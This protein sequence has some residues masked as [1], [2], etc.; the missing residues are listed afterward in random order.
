MRRLNRFIQGL[1]TFLYYYFVC[2]FTNRPLRVEFTNAIAWFQRRQRESDVFPSL[3]LTEVL[4]EASGIDIHLNNFAY[5]GGN[6]SFGELCALAAMVRV[7]KPK[8]LFEFG[9]F[10][11]NTTLQLALN[12][13]RD[14]VV[15]TIDLP[16]GTQKTKLKISKGDE[17]IAGERS[18]HR[19]FNGTEFEHRIRPILEDSATYDYSILRTRV[20]LVFVDGSH[21]YEYIENDTQRALELLA[22]HGI[23]IWHDYLVWNDV[24]DYLNDLSQRLP[25]RHIRST[26]LVVYKA[27]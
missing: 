7:L 14:A 25:L 23:I 1:W 4:S 9:T 17:V 20:D 18:S 16:H 10:D 6:V 8:T 21:S 11:G 27:A 5:R 15:Y 22:P 12:S 24:T 19:R 2:Y 3:E 13:P 26:S